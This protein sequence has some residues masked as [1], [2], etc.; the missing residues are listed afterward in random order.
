MKKF[1]YYFILCAFPIF[2]TTPISEGSEE[3]SHPEVILMDLNSPDFRMPVGRVAFL[4]LKR[5]IC[6]D[7]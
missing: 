3:P 7:V 2:F 6:Y 5:A 4:H 1:V